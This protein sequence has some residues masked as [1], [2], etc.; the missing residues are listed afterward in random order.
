MKETFELNCK[1]CGV[2]RV[3]DTD[4]FPELADNTCVAYTCAGC[5]KKRV[6]EGKPIHTC[7]GL[8]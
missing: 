4:E 7:V 8:N 3:I 2:L 1:D 6:A 5:V